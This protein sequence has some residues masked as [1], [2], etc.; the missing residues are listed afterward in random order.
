LWTCIE[1]LVGD[2][3]A[4]SSSVLGAA[5]P[6]VEVSA[7]LIGFITTMSGLRQSVEHIVGELVVVSPSTLMCCTMACSLPGLTTVGSLNVV[8]VAVEDEVVAAAMVV[9]DG[10]G[11]TEVLDAAREV[12]SP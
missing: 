8:V 2:I 11:V 9:V 4:P 7:A 6:I 3:L 1:Q 10:E 5:C 12:G